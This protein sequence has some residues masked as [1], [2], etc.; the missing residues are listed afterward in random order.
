MQCHVPCALRTTRNW[1]PEVSQCAQSR[2]SPWQTTASVKQFVPH[3]LHMSLESQSI[4][5]KIHSN[6]QPMNPGVDTPLKCSLTVVT[7]D[8]FDNRS[9]RL[10]RRGGRSVSMRLTIPFHRDS[11]WVC[12]EL[13]GTINNCLP[14][15]NLPSDCLLSYISG[16]IFILTKPFYIPGNILRRHW[17]ISSRQRLGVM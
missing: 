3:N 6:L 7:L 4:S 10:Y 2:G 1:C 15:R 11:G 17:R 16:V 14:M 12:S 5:I 8:V 9:V 13:A